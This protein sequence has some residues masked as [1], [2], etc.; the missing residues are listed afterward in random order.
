MSRRWKRRYLQLFI[1][2]LLTFILSYYLAELIKNIVKSPRPC[3]G[4]TNC[5]QGYSFP[6]RHTLIAFALT[7]AFMLE[8]KNKILSSLFAVTSIFIGALRVVT[9]AHRPEDVIVGAI[10]GIIVGFVVQRFYLF[11]RFWY[12]ESK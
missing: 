2:L 9:L 5:P 1:T 12:S 4:L 7:T 8:T 10:L 6:S 3:V 11:L